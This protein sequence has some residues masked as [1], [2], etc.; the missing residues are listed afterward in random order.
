MIGDSGS[1]VSRAGKKTEKPD[2][3]EDPARVSVNFHGEANRV[4]SAFVRS[5]ILGVDPILDR[6]PRGISS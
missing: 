4:G 3:W 6:T 2:P 5:L 1:A